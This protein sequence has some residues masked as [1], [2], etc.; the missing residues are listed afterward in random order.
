MKIS[1]PLLKIIARGLAL[2]CVLAFAFSFYSWRHPALPAT[3]GVPPGARV[4]YS[5]RCFNPLMTGPA[6]YYRI[7]SPLSQ[8]DTAVYFNGTQEGIRHFPG[9]ATTKRDFAGVSV[10]GSAHDQVLVFDLTGE[11]FP[12]ESDARCEC[13]VWKTISGSTT[14]MLVWTKF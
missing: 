13:R 6:L 10:Q 11:F 2:I 14:E 12:T 4:A 8:H 7:E 9:S 5:L 1:S 3:I